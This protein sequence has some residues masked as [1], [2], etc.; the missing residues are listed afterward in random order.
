MFI[1][2]NLDTPEQTDTTGSDTSFP[3]YHHY[4]LGFPVV[5]SLFTSLFSF[6][7]IINVPLWTNQ[8]V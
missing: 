2:W 8:L 7:V 6:E 5:Q 3:S 4:T 1:S